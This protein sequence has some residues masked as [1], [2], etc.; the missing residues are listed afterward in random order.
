MMAPQAFLAALGIGAFAG[1]L[2][3]RIIYNNRLTHYQ[4]VIANYRDVLE[5]KIPARALRPFPTKRN[6]KMFFGLVLIFGGVA[7]VFF[8][9]LIIS[10][11]WKSPPSHEL[12]KTNLAVQTSPG[13]GTPWPANSTAMHWN[14]VLGT[15]RSVDRMY[16][17]FLD[18]KG[19]ASKSTKLNRAFLESAMTG[20][21]IEMGI[22]EQRLDEPYPISEAN[23]IPPNGFIRLVAVLN[24]SPPDKGIPNDEFFR[25]WGKL[26]FNAIYEQGQPDR[27]A[28]DLTGYF[29][30]VAG[31]HVTRK[32]DAEKK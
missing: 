1:W 17:L 26:W 30:E 23:P 22:A 25:K 24:P 12:T 19:P 11:E 7:A 9:A 28:F 21:V 8:G 18:G 3:A 29:P 4:E 31:P 15:Q 32:T 5:E 2:L 6:K 27:L 14:E 16:S 10:F 20:E 13:S